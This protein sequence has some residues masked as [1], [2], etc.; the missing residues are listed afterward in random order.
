MQW[1]SFCALLISRHITSSRFI[2]V[3]SGRISLFFKTKYKRIYA[4]TTFSSFILHCTIGWFHMKKPFRVYPFP[5]VFSFFQCKPWENGSGS[6]GDFLPHLRGIY[7]QIKWGFQQLLGVESPPRSESWGLQDLPVGGR[8]KHIH[9]TGKMWRPFT[10]QA[11]AECFAYPHSP[12]SAIPTNVQLRAVPGHVDCWWW[13]VNQPEE[14]RVAGRKGGQE[15][16]TG[17]GWADG[18]FFIASLILT[19]FPVKSYSSCFCRWEN[20]LSQEFS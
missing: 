19:P 18:F 6:V 17:P 4:H 9:W 10:L 16:I 7:M 2:H 20:F 14:G 3:A 5:A 12:P 8:H 15:G 13:R 1:L 11:Q